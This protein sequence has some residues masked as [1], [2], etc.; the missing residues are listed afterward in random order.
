MVRASYF[1]TLLRIK[2]IMYVA[3]HTTRHLFHC[4][5]HVLLESSRHVRDA[6]A[7]MQKFTARE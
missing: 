3:I 7:D 6:G 4:K 2:I 1:S 5:Q